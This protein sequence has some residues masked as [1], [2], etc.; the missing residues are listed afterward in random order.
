LEGEYDSETTGAVKSASK[1]RRQSVAPAPSYRLTPGPGHKIF[2]ARAEP[3]ANSRGHTLHCQMV[4]M[5][6]WIM[7]RILVVSDVRIV[8]EGLHSVLAQ[9]N[10]VDIISTVDMRHATHRSA[11]LNPDIVLFDAV[12]LESIGI[13]RDLVASSPHTKVVAFGVKEIDA[14]ILALAAAGT[15]GCVCD[16]AASDDMVKVL[17]QVLCEEP[18]GPPQTAALPYPPLARRSHDGGDNGNAY[19]MP[20]S[21]RELQIAHLIETGLTNKQIARQLGIVAATVKNHVH[22]MCEKLKVHRRGEVAARTRALLR[23]CAVFPVSQ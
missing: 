21:R 13:V 16:S 11:Q 17:Q 5:R 8:L 18:P 3:F 2:I 15:A 9:Q 22:N 23:A 19:P 4:V 14:Q 20:L 12:R 10:G 6:G 7:I 1:I